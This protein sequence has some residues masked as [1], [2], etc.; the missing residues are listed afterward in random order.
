MRTRA[1]DWDLA[2]GRS[3]LTLVVYRSVSMLVQ[4]EGRSQWR[5]ESQGL[6][7]TQVAVSLRLGQ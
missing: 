4:E 7:A 2:C 3:T 6:G 5:A 1:H